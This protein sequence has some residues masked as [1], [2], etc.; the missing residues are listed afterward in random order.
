M[1]NIGRFAIGVLAGGAWNLASLSCLAQLL[2]A[3]LGQKPSQRRAIGWLLIKFPVL[4][5]LAVFLFVQHV[6]SPATFGIGFTVVLVMV[7]GW[8]AWKPRWLASAR[9]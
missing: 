6:V 3:W 2:R 7:L 5:G 1:T 4:Y 9:L 8:L